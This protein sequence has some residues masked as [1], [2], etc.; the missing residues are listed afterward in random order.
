MENFGMI[1]GAIFGL[2]GI[3]YGFFQNARAT[4][5]LETLSGDKGERAA[6]VEREQKLRGEL[7][8]LKNKLSKTSKALESARSDNQKK[9]KREQKKAKVAKNKAAQQSRGPSAEEEALREDN[10]RLKKSIEA[11]E[12]QV[13]AA[14][15]EAA[16][17]LKAVADAPAPKA[18]PA[19]AESAP[20]A[21][22]DTETADTSAIEAKLEQA[23]SRAKDAEA[24][25]AKAEKAGAK[26]KSA[27][28]D[29][30]SSLE[31][32]VDALEPSV[33]EVLAQLVRRTTQFEKLY[34]AAEGQRQQAQEKLA[35]QQK[36]YFAVCRELAVAAGHAE[37][38]SD[39]NARTAA[40]NIVK[41]GAAADGANAKPA[42]P[43]AS[44]TDT[45]KDT[46]SAAD[47]VDAAPEADAAAPAESTEDATA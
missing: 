22:K 12:I 15:K 21:P 6:L 44:K 3:V 25:L 27:K 13:K 14:K 31:I 43:K 10:K 29:A 26:E 8:G 2:I 30:L 47:A 35:T 19:K 17:A 34:A 20:S 32:D 18:T 36:R 33:A 45:P 16:E 24:A 41:L 7:D 42:A 23:L 40:E 5:A 39:D 4:K 11:M 28:K 1:G 46:S 37:T 9:Q 38:V